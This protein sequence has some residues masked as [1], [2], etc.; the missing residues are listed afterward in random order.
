MADLEKA[1]EGVA[2]RLRPALI[3][4]IPGAYK[5]ID[6]VMANSKELVLV[7]H[8]LKQIVNVKGD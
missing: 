2:T 8:T 1:M 5:D 3:D 7:E 4:E 6:E